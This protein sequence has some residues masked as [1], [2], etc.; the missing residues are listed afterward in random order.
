MQALSYAQKIKYV[1]SAVGK[2][3]KC[4]FLEFSRMKKKKEFNILATTSSLIVA[5]VFGPV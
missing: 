4:L 5:H 3:Y 2:K 1:F